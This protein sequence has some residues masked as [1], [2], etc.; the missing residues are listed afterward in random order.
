MTDSF[1]IIISPAKKMSINDTYGTTQTSPLFLNEAHLIY[2][3]LQ[4]LSF[5]SLKELLNCNDTLALQ[6]YNRLK[7]L[8]ILNP[9]SYALGS[10]V[11]LQYQSIAAHILS[12]DAKEYVNNHLFILSGLYG[13]LRPTDQIIL[14]R[15]E[16]QAKLNFSNTYDLYAFHSNH[17]NKYF[18]G[19]NK[20]ILNLASNEYAKLLTSN[21]NLKIVDVIFYELDNGKYKV[22]ATSAKMARG[23]M[24]RFLAENNIAC[25]EDVKLFNEYQF[26][27]NEYLSSDSKIVFVKEE[28]K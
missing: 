17:I 2:K 3:E 5:E 14:Y 26:K 13:I 25:I 8:D 11:G 7:E 4:S 27:Y 6:A 28:R 16:M 18:E 21:T 1:N 15:L 10:Y 9:V 24:V 20:T 23:A 19:L 22:K 12:D